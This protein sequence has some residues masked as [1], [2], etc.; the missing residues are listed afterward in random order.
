MSDT[1]KQ[2]PLGVNVQSSLLQNKGLGI[3]PVVIDLVGLS[4]YYANYTWGAV[5]NDTVLRLLT[6]SINDAYMR[7]GII[8]AARLTV[9][10]PTYENLITIG[11][12]TQQLG[13]VSIT[14]TPE[15][16]TVIHNTGSIGTLPA[17]TY[18][19]IT[20]DVALYNDVWL[21]NSSS[22]GTFTV[23]TTADPGPALGGTVIYNTL[24]PGLGNS[25]SFAFTYNGV[26]QG[27][28][29]TGVLDQTGLTNTFVLNPAPMAWGGN[30]WSIYRNKQQTQWGWARLF[31][32]QAYD[33]WNNNNTMFLTGEYK[34]YLASFMNAES[35][36]R[37]TN[38]A[39]MAM[40]NSKD[41]LKGTYS[42]MNDLI[43]AD[44]TGISLATFDFGQDLMKS[45]KAINLRRI[46]TFGLPANLLET[47]QENNAITKPVVLAMLGSGL[48]HAEISTIL[49]NVANATTE[50]QKKL[51]SAF[52][53]IVGQDLKDV[54]IALNCK[55]QGIETL[56]DLL[57]PKKLF[58]TKSSS[59]KYV[60]ETLTVPVY[61]STTQPTNSKTY[62]FIYGQG[63][64]NSQLSAPNV[65]EKVTPKVVVT[66]P[67]VTPIPKVTSEPTTIAARAVEQLATTQGIPAAVTAVKTIT[68]V[69]ANNVQNTQLEEIVRKVNPK[70]VAIQANDA[71][72]EK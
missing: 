36:V 37:Y 72:E 71:R 7:S 11:G 8:G 47:L 33:E 62:Y 55:T 56:V 28:F 25:N 43:S 24:S 32:H 58:P 63:S 14:S 34:D 49:T 27:P 54:L 10:T 64:T 2:S 39:I 60:Y 6:W 18:V 31:A 61:N 53:I 21:I 4:K 1:G 23:L 51:Y 59:G 45:G 26:T 29:G 20:S 17:G 13:I 41:F 42:N 3:N 9:D 35:F 46:N 12:A 16:F 52:L 69:A 15:S 44:I 68:E 30:N 19:K 70:L 57:N 22:Q 38:D 5:T 65:V 67:A 66:P 50:Q 40:D 48:T